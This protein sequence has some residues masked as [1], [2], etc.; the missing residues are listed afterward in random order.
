MAV[1]G[2]RVEEMDVIH[3]KGKYSQA[4]EYKVTNK[5]YITK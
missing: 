3:M 5:K 2:T 1:Y 4:R